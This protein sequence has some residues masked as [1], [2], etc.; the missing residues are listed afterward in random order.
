VERCT[1]C[2]GYGKNRMKAQNVSVK[3]QEEGGKA[4]KRHFT[5]KVPTC[6]R[7]HM[8]RKKYERVVV[9]LRFYGMI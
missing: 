1:R 9:Q 8:R 6:F 2:P 3:V 5:Q 7:T 4:S